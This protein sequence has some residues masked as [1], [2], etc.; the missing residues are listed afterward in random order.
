LIKQLFKKDENNPWT[1]IL[2]EV[3]AE[4]VLPAYD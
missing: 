2:I 1:S 4:R 3:T